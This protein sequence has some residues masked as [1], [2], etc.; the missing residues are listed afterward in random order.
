MAQWW[1][2]FFDTDFV[3]LWTGFTP[4]DE[5]D[6]AGLW[7]L[8]RLDQ[9]SRVL[10]APCGWGRLSRLLALRGGTV[11]G[12]DQS[13]PALDRAEEL[14]G[15]IPRDRLRYLRHD[16][17]NPLPESG[18]DAA[19]NV[20]SSIGYG[21]DEDDLTVFRNLRDAVRPGG[22]V[23]VETSHRDLAAATLS[24]GMKPSRRLSDGTLVVEEPVFDAIA[25]RVNT[26]WY[27]YG[28]SGQGQKPASIRVYSATELVKLLEQ[29]GLRYVSAFRGCSTE[30]FVG[31]G[32]DMGGR[33]AILTERPSG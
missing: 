28:P 16:L 13:Q 20:F 33:L 11:V 24:R 21:T 17:R 26:T 4:S 14:R 5:S 30:P 12:V 19:C 25:G 9:Q 6:A 8:L 31:S 32:P 22:L 10:D 1:E 29:A 2:T 15:D 27:W 18:F 7:A 23:L 3:K